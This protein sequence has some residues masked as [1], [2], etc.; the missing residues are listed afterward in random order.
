MPPKTYEDFLDF[1]IK[2]LTNYLPVHGLN[3]SRRKVEPVA[4]AY[5]I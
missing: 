5:L 1:S 3:T 4:R 2:D